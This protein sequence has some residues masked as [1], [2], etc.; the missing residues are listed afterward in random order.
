MG[1]NIRISQLPHEYERVVVYELFSG[2]RRG[3]VLSRR[4][5]VPICE[6]MITRV[7]RTCSGTRPRQLI[8]A[9]V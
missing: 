7:S 1:G 3:I 5:G 4:V 9:M 2:P 8:D 6:P